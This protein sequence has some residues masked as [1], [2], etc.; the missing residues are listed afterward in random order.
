MP[1]E[2]SFTNSNKRRK[3]SDHEYAELTFKFDSSAKKT[4]STVDT[5]ETIE[6]I[7]DLIKEIDKMTLNREEKMNQMYYPQKN[8]SMKPKVKTVSKNI[9]KNDKSPASSFNFKKV[10]EKIQ[11]EKKNDKKET[12]KTTN[13]SLTFNSSFQSF[14]SESNKSV[15]LKDI[16]FGNKLKTN[17]PQGRRNI[18]N[19]SSLK[20]SVLGEVS[21]IND[22]IKE[23]EY[24]MDE[25][26]LT[27][28]F[29][30]G[31][32]RD[33]SPV[34]EVK[35]FEND[36]CFLPK[37]K[38]AI[39]FSLFRDLDPNLNKAKAMKPIIK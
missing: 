4:A 25:E 9:F 24:L 22:N 37:M 36:N 3:L 11:N 16:L 7:N 6:N 15:R 10:F 28:T 20:K 32:M 39:N 17:N 12:K 14:G 19:I 30:N 18:R 1:V 33:I 27:P 13:S 8:E 35:E 23:E 38:S 34:Q 26:N 31:K 21:N 5:S 2:G 29:R